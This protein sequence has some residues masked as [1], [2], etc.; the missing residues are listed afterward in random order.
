MD[1]IYA[2]HLVMGIVNWGLIC[3]VKMVEIFLIQL[4][5]IRNIVVNGIHALW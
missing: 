5:M 4:I 1:R 3:Q 2:M